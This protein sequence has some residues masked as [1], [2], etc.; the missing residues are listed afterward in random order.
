MVAHAAKRLDGLLVIPQGPVR[1]G[2]V[3][4]S[5]TIALVDVSCQRELADEQH[6]ASVLRKREIHLAVVILEY[7]EPHH[8]VK[9]GCDDGFLIVLL[10]SEVDQHAFSDRTDGLSLDVHS[11]VLDALDDRQHQEKLSIASE[12]ILWTNALL[13]EA[14]K[15]ALPVTAMSAPAATTSW[16]VSRLTPP[17]TLIRKS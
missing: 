10:D 6:V 1:R 15:N 11:C 13:S 2:C 7:P 12:C 14:S 3:V 5:G 17:S 8:L 9:K 4:E 16:I